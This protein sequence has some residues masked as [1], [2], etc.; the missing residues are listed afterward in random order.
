M[1]SW[2]EFLTQRG[3]RITQGEV[4]DF[5]DPSTELLAATNTA[6]LCDLS[7]WSV[8]RVSGSDAAAF[9]H[10]QLT[11]DVKSLSVRRAQ[12]SAYC[13]PKGRM[14]ANF[15]LSRQ[16]EDV[17]ELHLPANQADTVKKRL[18]LFILRAKV[19]IEDV[20]QETIHIG[21]GGAPEVSL[22][23]IAHLLNRQ[24][25]QFSWE[26]LSNGSMLALPG[27]RYCLSLSPQHAP[28]FWQRL[29]ERARPVGFAVWKWLT[30]RSGIPII[31]PVTQD[32]FIPQMVN[33]DVL[34][35][36]SFN[37]GC[38]PGQ[39]IVARTQYLGKIKQ[40]LYLAHC[41]TALAPGEK[42]FSTEFG[43]QFAGMV[44]NA[45]PAPTGGYD[46]LA[47][48]QV[49][50]AQSDIHLASPTGALIQLFT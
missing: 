22:T 46:F 7:S 48:L 24:P 9:L 38:Y 27:D 14:L 39:E 44:V 17:F 18:S 16:A 21:I 2:H 49:S 26:R 33:W 5:G 3:A 30:I 23:L 40:R 15:V 10:G 43:E 4:S 29:T 47:V 37:K 11:S 41:E 8:L 32:Q 34:G 13:S 20:T 31:L 19:G 1:T 50:S 28:E 6:V 36:I 45:A 12:L 35:G 25:T 42:L